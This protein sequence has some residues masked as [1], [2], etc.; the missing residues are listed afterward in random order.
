MYRKLIC[1]R[2]GSYGKMIYFDNAATSWPKPPQVGKAM[3]KYLKETGASPGRSGHR[4]SVQAARLVYDTREKLTRLFNASDPLGIVFTK[5]ATEAINIAG[6]IC[7][8]T[9]RN[10]VVEEL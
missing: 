7:I 8:Y 6:G 9:N 3:Q 10:V 2:K 1:R 4:L 5:N